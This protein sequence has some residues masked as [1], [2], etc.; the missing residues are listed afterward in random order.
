MNDSLITVYLHLMT[1]DTG[2]V[3]MLT[4]IP[5]TPSPSTQ[6]PNSGEQNELSNFQVLGI[7]S[8]VGAVLSVV[9]F[10]F[11]SLLLYWRKTQHHR[12]GHNYVPLATREDSGTHTSESLESDTTSQ[13]NSFFVEDVLADIHR[14]SIVLEGNE[15]AGQRDRGC[16]LALVPPPSIIAGQETNEEVSIPT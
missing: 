6:N 10:I 7:A 13:P 12:Q 8:T 14:N 5:L 4:T 15:E 16:S 3:T 1:A 11:A 9:I 2:T